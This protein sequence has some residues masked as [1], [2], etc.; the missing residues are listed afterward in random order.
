[1]SVGK[2]GDQQPVDQSTLPQDGFSHLS[3]QRG[4][5]RRQRIDRPVGRG[6]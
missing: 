6:V 4:K 2:Q 1:M 5:L 3:A